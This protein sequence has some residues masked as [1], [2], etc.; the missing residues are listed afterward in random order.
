MA[1]SSVA[2]GNYRMREAQQFRFRGGS[3]SCGSGYANQQRPQQ[4]LA[5]NP[6]ATEL[7]ADLHKALKTLALHKQ[8]GPDASRNEH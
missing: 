1:S 5:N 2:V 7:E 3:S 6:T 4:Q 8:P